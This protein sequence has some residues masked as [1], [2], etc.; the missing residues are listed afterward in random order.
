MA[1]WN[2]KQPDK[3]YGYFFIHWGKKSTHSQHRSPVQGK[4]EELMMAAP[5]NHKHQ[6]CSIE[7]AVQ[8]SRV[9]VVSLLIFWIIIR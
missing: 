3:I 9:A 4:G 7:A 5:A 6:Q 1:I 8:D 2:H